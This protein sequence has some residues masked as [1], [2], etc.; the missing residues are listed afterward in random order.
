MREPAAGNDPELW[1][2]LS[3]A[4]PAWYEALVGMGTTWRLQAGQPPLLTALSL[5]HRLASHL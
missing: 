4:G 1:V 2:W 3:P 5:L